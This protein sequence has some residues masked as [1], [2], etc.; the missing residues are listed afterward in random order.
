VREG[1]AREEVGV[2][3]KRD[4]NSPTAQTRARELTAECTD[5]RQRLEEKKQDVSEFCA[6]VIELEARLDA[7]RRIAEIVGPEKEQLL[8]I[9]AIASS[10]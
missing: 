8:I 6:R 3:V 9:S 1:D 5:L 7:I 4:A 10:S 2:V